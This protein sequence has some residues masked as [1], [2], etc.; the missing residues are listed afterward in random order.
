MA[1]SD[2]PLLEVTDVSFS[3]QNHPALKDINIRIEEGE[4]AAITGPNGGGKSTL[5]HLILQFDRPNTGHVRLW[6]KPPRKRLSNVGYVPQRVIVNTSLPLTV[7]D[8]VLMGSISRTHMLKSY[9]AA[10]KQNTR[11]ALEKV[12]LDEHRTR[13][14]T[15]LSGGQRQRALLARA[16]ISKPSLLLL[17]EPLANIDPTWQHQLYHLLKELREEHNTTIL[18]VTHDITPIREQLDYVICVNQTVTVHE[19]QTTGEHTHTITSCYE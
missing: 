13:P 5:L 3:Y 19:P 14:F 10:D 11:E 16:L 7:F 6:G 8:V 4:F 17:D 9:S 1:E 15:E 12:G 2:S 18:L